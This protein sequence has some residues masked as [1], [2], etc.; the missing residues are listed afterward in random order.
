MYAYVSMKG[1]LLSYNFESKHKMTTSISKDYFDCFWLSW[2]R[3]F[4][5]L[6]LRLQNIFLQIFRF[7]NMYSDKERP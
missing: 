2:M 3:H 6:E 5:I 4:S 7:C 1:I